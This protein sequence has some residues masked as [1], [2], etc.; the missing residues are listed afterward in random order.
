MAEK[1]SAAQQK[2]HDWI[3]SG[4][5]EEMG[6]I[7]TQV[8]A[9]M[10]ELIVELM[11][12]KREA[13]HWKQSFQTTLNEFKACVAAVIVKRGTGKRL[14]VTKAHYEKSIGKQLSAGQLDGGNTRVYELIDAPPP[15]PKQS[16]DTPGIINL[17]G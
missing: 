1:L 9:M 2:A 14:I 5:A 15:N 10:A 11:D 6:A 3:K 7:G 16:N 12:A 4:S 13:A 17:N 8:G